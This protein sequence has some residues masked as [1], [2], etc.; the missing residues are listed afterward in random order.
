MTKKS[1]LIALGISLCLGHLMAATV[2][3]QKAQTVAVNFYKGNVSASATATPLLVYTRS[4]SD[5][6]V[7]YYVFNIAPRGFVIVSGD[8]NI[9]PVIG[10]SGESDFRMGFEQYGYQGLD[11]PCGAA[12][13]P[14][15]PQWRTCR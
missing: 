15:Y 5:G 13:P 12:Y 9:Q 8:D 14:L 1:L 7:D 11:R 4:E 10:Y 2:S 3:V 6:I